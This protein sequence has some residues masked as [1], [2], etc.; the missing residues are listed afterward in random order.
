MLAHMHPAEFPVTD[1]R[2]D[3]E[4]VLRILEETP[5]IDRDTWRRARSSWAAPPA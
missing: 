2:Q 4:R 5:A 1:H 3:L